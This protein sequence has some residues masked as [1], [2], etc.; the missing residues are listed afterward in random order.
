MSNYV[1]Q[2]PY[3]SGSTTTYEPDGTVTSDGSNMPD[4]VT[5]CTD[6]HNTTY[7]GGGMT[8]SQKNQFKTFGTSWIQN[9]NWNTSPHGSADA[10]SSDT[11]KRKPPYNVNKNYVLSCTDC[12]ETHGSPNRMLIRKEVNG[13]SV[14][15]FT[16]WDSRADWLTLC[17][18]CH[19]V[20]SGHK[21]GNPCSAC[22]L[23]D[24]SWSKPI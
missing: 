24:P 9:P 18:R 12:H 3:S 4:Y 16:S 15:T 11:M 22:H 1:Y 6:C 7:N 2:A 20:G 5:F 23:H 14:V 17:Q 10:S 8:S 13:E 21:S 19:T